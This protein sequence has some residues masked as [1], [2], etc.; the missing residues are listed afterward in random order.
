MLSDTIFALSSGGL[1]AGVAV[2][3]V[4][5]SA[6]TSVMLAMTGR[7]PPPRQ[8]VYT[9][10]RNGDGEILD[11]GL[12]IYFKAPSSFTGEDSAE[13]Q[14]HGGRGVVSAILAVI[15]ELEGTRPAEAGEFARRAFLNGRL[16]LTEAEALSDLIAAETDVQRR[17]AISNAGGKQREVY[18]SWRRQLISVRAMIEAELDFSDEADVSARI[19]SEHLD[20]IGAL[21]R[22]MRVH[23][24]RRKIGQI[25]RD[26]FK[27][28]ILGAPNAGK[29]SLLNMLAGQ[30]AAIVS[31]EPGTT[32]DMIVASVDIKG[33]RVDFVDT[34][35]L[36]ETTGK[37]ERIGIDRAL[38]A[39]TTADLVLAVYDLSDDMVKIA[40]PSDTPHI[41]V[42][43][44]FDLIEYDAAIRRG[45]DVDVVVSSRS[46]Y[47]MDMLIERVSDFL[48]E[49]IMHE[50]FALPTRARHVALIAEAVGHLSNVATMEG[51]ELVAEEL[52]LAGNA[53]G[54]L[55][56]AIDTE[57]VLGVIFSEFC[58]GK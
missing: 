16:D 13:F 44:K 29:S 24:D 20:Q 26:G 27:V 11:R 36:R 23:L 49:M 43:S 18:E 53:I 8:A 5:G 17:L 50:G 33:Y 54:R 28:V 51:L 2:I 15:S 40:V 57:E 25:V 48:P 55:T 42:G 31:D 12:V 14:I 30:D 35:G 6:T 10:I 41:R 38:A 19:L 4:S 3:R 9:A 34:A 32:R 22:D 52:R 1:P 46:G 21:E 58:I 47:G 39:A 7:V 56:G 37:V 45:A